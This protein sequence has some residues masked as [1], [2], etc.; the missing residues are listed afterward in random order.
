MRDI[1]FRGSQADLLISNVNTMAACEKSMNWIMRA[2]QRQAGQDRIR[3]YKDE[4]GESESR[5]GKSDRRDLNG[6][7]QDKGQG[8]TP[9]NCDEPCRAKRP[10]LTHQKHAFSTRNGAVD[11]VEPQPD[12]SYFI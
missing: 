1:T 9:A 12:R 8:G 11:E 5:K 2:T 10:L 6:C 4:Q 3:G 7:H